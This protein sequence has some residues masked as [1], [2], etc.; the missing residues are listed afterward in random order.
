MRDS[1]QLIPDE[2]VDQAVI[3]WKN[4]F[5][6]EDAKG[7]VFIGIDTSFFYQEKYHS[8]MIDGVVT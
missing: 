5:N 4:F 6:Q 2:W 7:R 3:R 8:K 1:T